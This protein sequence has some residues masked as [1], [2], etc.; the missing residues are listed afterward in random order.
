MKD[1]KRFNFEPRKLLVQIIEIYLHF[2]NESE[3]LEAIVR[4]VRS[5]KVEVFKQALD[6][7]T[8]WSLLPVDQIQQFVMFTSQCQE[9]LKHAEHL[10][11]E[12]Y[13]DIPDEF[14]D[15]ISCT[16]MKDPVLLPTSGKIVDRAVIHRHLLTVSNDPFTRAHLTEDMLVPQ[17]QLKTKIQDWLKAKKDPKEQQKN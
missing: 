12:E 10:K 1:P 2:S 7:L 8:K 13:D 14:I 11:E 15:P 3:F 17:S 6:L 5:F 4:D 9:T 16:L